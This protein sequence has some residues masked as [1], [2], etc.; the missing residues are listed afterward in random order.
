LTRLSA[1]RGENAQRTS[2]PANPALSA[3]RELLSRPAGPARALRD[4]KIYKAFVATLDAFGAARGRLSPCRHA[5]RVG[6]YPPR[7][8]LEGAREGPLKWLRPGRGWRPPADIGS[9]GRG[10]VKGSSWVLA[11]SPLP[12]GRKEGPGEGRRGVS[13]DVEDAPKGPS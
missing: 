9:R 1:L 13:A 2:R 6:G 7:V 11:R 4:G 8:S 12:R 3:P 5:G 10:G